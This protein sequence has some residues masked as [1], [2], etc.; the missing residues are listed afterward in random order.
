M[1]N[2]GLLIVGLLLTLSFAQTDSSM[3]DTSTAATSSMMDFAGARFL[4][5]ILCM[6]SCKATTRSSVV[7]LYVK[8]RFAMRLTC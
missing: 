4:F 8:R 6:K 2:I 3:S 5:V 1:K 7:Q